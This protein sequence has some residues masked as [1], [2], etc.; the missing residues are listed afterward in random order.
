MSVSSNFCKLKTFYQ[1]IMSSF[2]LPIKISDNIVRIQNETDHHDVTELFLKVALKP[3]ILTLTPNCT[4]TI[5]IPD[6]NVTLQL[7]EPVNQ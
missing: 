2:T 3:I 4:L 6:Y 1:S 7:L 5:K